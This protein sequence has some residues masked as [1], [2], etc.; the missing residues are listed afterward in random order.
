MAKLKKDFS[1]SDLIKQNM[2]DIQKIQQEKPIEQLIIYALALASRTK[3]ALKDFK[4]AWFDEY[5][6]Y[7]FF[8][9]HAVYRK[10]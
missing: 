4:A 3:L 9:L 8:P 7:E 10:N 2:I 6:Y 5:N 1:F